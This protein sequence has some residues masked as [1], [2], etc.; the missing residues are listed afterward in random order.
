M[1]CD[2]KCSQKKRVFAPERATQCWLQTQLH[3][4]I[5]SNL[6]LDD[7]QHSASGYSHSQG[8]CKLHMYCSAATDSSA[9]GHSI[10]TSNKVEA[11]R[12]GTTK[13][14]PRSQKSLWHPNR[15][16]LTRQ[17]PQQSSNH[18]CRTNNKDREMV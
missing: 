14:L 12:L 13:D 4:N 7:R 15:E 6:I 16:T 9:S 10:I 17:L 18:L 3:D 8:T 2:N 1:H 5:M 11:L